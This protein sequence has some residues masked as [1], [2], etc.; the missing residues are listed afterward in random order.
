MKL[1]VTGA[2]GLL[3]LNLGL[4]MHARH[5]IT[6][7][8]RSK[9]SG[10]PFELLRADLLDTG[11]EHRILDTVRPDAVIHCAAMADLDAC[12]SDPEG[13]RRINAE[14]PGELAAACAGR[15]IRLLHISTDAVFDGTKDGIYTEADTPN[16]LGVYSRSKLDGERAVL[17]ANAGAIVARVNFHGWSLNGG[18]SLSEFFF[19]GL[20]AGRLVSGFTDVWFC[21]LFVGDLAEILIGMLEKGLTGLYHVVGTEALTKY[22]FGLRIARQFGFDE[23][24]V[25]PTSVEESGLKARRAHNLRLSV[26]KLS[27]DLGHEIP[28]VSTGIAQFHAQYQQ[29]Y[30]QKLRSYAQERTR[31][32]SQD[33]HPGG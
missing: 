24:L 30:P 28:G 17:S 7:V 21:P 12:E 29:G 3:G 2:S 20:S 26:H 9:L 16:P 10:V 31:S 25:I 23:G 6:G 5:E 13:A 22:E 11:L 4:L 27:T 1:L 18:R 19:N 32:I 15:G 33:A 8:D 14:L